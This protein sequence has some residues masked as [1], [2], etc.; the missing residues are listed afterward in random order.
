MMLTNENHFYA[1]PSYTH[2]VDTEILGILNSLN[3]Q[4][5]SAL[6]K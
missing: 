2:G 6:D 1:T 3:I 4:E 5:F